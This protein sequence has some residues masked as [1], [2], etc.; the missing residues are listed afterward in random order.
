MTPHIPHPAQL[1][2]HSPS[3]RPPLDWIAR[4]DRA[5]RRI[6]HDIQR[7]IATPRVLNGK[8]L[9]PDRL[10]AARHR[11]DAEFQR[12]QYSHAM[13]PLVFL[14]SVG[15]SREDMARVFGTTVRRIIRWQ[16]RADAPDGRLREV[17]DA[18]DALRR[19][20]EAFGALL[21]KVHRA[22]GEA[23]L[24]RWFARPH[25]LLGGRSPR[26]TLAAGD[27]D[28]TGRV[29]YVTREMLVGMSP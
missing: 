19:E 7:F 24:R 10:F 15:L 6:E 12:L 28:T 16:H 9:S 17:C 2:A 3:R 13:R 8:R 26:H 22:S 14:E 1:R 29:I 21:G 4:H 23:V 5:R 27:R 11:L 20:A 18:V 25:P